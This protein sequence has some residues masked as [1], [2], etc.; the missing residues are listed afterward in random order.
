MLITSPGLRQSHCPINGQTKAACGPEESVLGP[1]PVLEVQLTHYE[2]ERNTNEQEKFCCRSR[3]TDVW[4]FRSSSVRTKGSH[5]R[6]CSHVSD[7]EHCR[8]RG[9][10][11]GPHHVGRSSQGGRP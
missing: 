5:G 10:L 7:Q 11:Q 9:Q 6:R 2:S 8:K 3:R 1:Q 4:I